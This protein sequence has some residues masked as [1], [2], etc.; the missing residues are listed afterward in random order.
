MDPTNDALLMEVA[1][2]LVN[3]MDSLWVRVLRGKYNMD[4][5]RF[6]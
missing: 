4:V 5:N 1:W 2:G 6:R 3:E